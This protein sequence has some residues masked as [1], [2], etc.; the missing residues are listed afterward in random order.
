LVSHFSAKRGRPLLVEEI[1]PDDFPAQLGRI[2]PPWR[3]PALRGFGHYLGLHPQEFNE[4]W[5]T[6]IAAWPADD[7]AAWLEGFGVGA[8][9]QRPFAAWTN[10]RRAS[11]G[12]RN[13][14]LN[15]YYRGFG[16]ALFGRSDR[17]D[18]E[19]AALGLLADEAPCEPR[20]AESLRLARGSQ[21]PLQTLIGRPWSRDS[22]W[23]RRTG[24]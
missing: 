1:P 11:L 4:A 14:R 22:A 17:P 13:R 16:R 23:P 9:E 12:K 24:S 20:D 19:P 7:K 6:A 2:A 21:A 8:I 15:A 3:T 5:E 10:R 18:A